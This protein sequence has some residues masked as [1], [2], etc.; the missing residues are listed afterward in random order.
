MAG[1]EPCNGWKGKL[2][3]WPFISALGS[4]THLFFSS[5]FSGGGGGNN[6]TNKLPT[7]C[8]AFFPF[9]LPHFSTFSVRHFRLPWH[10][11]GRSFLFNNMR[12]YSSGHCCGCH[13]R[14]ACVCV[15]QALG[16][17]SGINVLCSHIL[18]YAIARPAF[19][20]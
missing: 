5:V 13:T 15:W 17:R 1:G 11:N 10:T 19:R 14:V 8:L 20:C 2:I 18:I 3:L 16:A 6:K 9:L 12:Y 4:A 7:S